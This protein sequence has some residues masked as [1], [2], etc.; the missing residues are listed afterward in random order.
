MYVCIVNRDGEILVHRHMPARPDPFLKAM[1]P[2]REDLGV[3]VACLVTWDL[4]RR[5]LRS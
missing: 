1:A 4:A 5:P 2:D 3:C